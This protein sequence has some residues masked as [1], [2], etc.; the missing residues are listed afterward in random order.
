MQSP[1]RL[2]GRVVRTAIRRP[3]TRVMS[4][5]GVTLTR[6]RHSSSLELPTVRT[7][8]LTTVSPTTFATRMHSKDYLA[9]PRSMVNLR[10]GNPL[11]RPTLSSAHTQPT[12]RMAMPTDTTSQRATITSRRIQMATNRRHC[13]RRASELPESSPSPS[14]TTRLP[15]GTLWLLEDGIMVRTTSAKTTLAV[16]VKSLE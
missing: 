11:L 12:S 15:I 7:G 1:T 8:R 4:M 2:L 5:Q 10:I 13:T 14:A 6:A 16:L 9:S 3:W